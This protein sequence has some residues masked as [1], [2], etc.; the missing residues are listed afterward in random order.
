MNLTQV[1]QATSSDFA[2]EYSSVER[3]THDYSSTT[4]LF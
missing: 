3:I 2:K 4:Q 1:V